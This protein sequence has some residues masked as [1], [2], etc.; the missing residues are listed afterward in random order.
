MSK[1]FINLMVEAFVKD[2]LENNSNSFNWSEPVSFSL[3]CDSTR[4]LG[5]SD[6]YKVRLVSE[7]ALICT[8]IE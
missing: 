3:Y 4:Y 2:I 1:E 5:K 8:E 6:H 7:K